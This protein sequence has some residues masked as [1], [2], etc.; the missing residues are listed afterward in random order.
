MATPASLR[1]ALRAGA[2]RFY[3]ALTNKDFAP[4]ELAIVAVKQKSTA[5]LRSQQSGGV[6]DSG[7]SYSW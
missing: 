3:I 4:T 6:I 5:T 1:E 2:F 7:R